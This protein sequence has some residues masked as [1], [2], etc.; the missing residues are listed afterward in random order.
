LQQERRQYDVEAKLSEENPLE[1]VLGKINTPFFLISFAQSEGRCALAI[2]S[3]TVPNTVLISIHDFERT[4]RS[5][6][7]VF[8]LAQD[9]FK[10]LGNGA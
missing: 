4:D 10:I 3:D 9:R 5:L 6:V 8:D 1:Q 2:P 7:P